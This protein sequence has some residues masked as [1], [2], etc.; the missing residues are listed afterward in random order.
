[1][2]QLSVK[3]YYSSAEIAAL[4]LS[5]APSATKNVLAKAKRENWVY[6]SRSGKGGGIE[7]EFSSLPI[8]IQ[9]EILLKEKIAK[10]PDF[11]NT[12]I[13]KVKAQ[14]RVMT[15][16]AWNV[17][18]SATNEQERRA[19]HRFNAVMKLKG[20]LDMRLKLMDAMDRV[21]EH[22]AGQEGEAVSRGSLKRWWYKVKNHPQS[23]WLPLLLDRVE[24]DTTNRY[25]EI[26]DKAWQFF[27]GE[28]CRQ[29]QPNFAICYEE[30]M[31]A[32]EKNGWVVPSLNTLKRKFDLHPKSWTK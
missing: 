20:L 30:L 21:V 2:K 17:L 4:K 18:A 8:D 10:D 19:E 25:A 23:N 28:Y 32:A 3:Q 16:S 31:Y 26:D 13:K 27:L 9:A 11:K 7:F 14:E 12:K 29:A 6:R 5:S 22:F 1:M 24:R 15:E